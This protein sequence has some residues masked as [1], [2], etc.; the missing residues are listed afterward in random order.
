MKK[1][2]DL[3]GVQHLWEKIVGKFVAKEEGKG[4]ST[5]DYTTEEK[6]KLEG[7]A[8]GANNYVHPDTAG[9]KHIPAGGS[10]GQ[11]LT[12]ESDG[13]AKW[14]APVE[15]TVD[16]EL[17]ETST[18][19]IQN[20]AVY[21]ALQGKVD[22]TTLGQKNGV[23]TLDETGLIP[24]TQLPSYVDDVIEGYYDAEA[25]KFYKEEGKTTEITGESGK[26]YVDL[27][28][29]MSYRY[30]GSTFV[31]ITSSDMVALTNDELDTVLV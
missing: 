30:S 22:T 5:N 7:I 28:T 31:Q 18:N 8:E 15:A 12:Y 6:T 19:A 17:N 4:L 23:A 16:A 9:N 14:A 11:V 1:Y 10:E 13:T 21:T 25:G 26:I 24:S 2:L 3:S 29:N 27:A 20:K